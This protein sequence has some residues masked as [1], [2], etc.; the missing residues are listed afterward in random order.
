LRDGKYNWVLKSHFGDGNKKK[1]KREEK[2]RDWVKREK[3]RKG[4]G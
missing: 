4:K 1:R 2:R 3:G